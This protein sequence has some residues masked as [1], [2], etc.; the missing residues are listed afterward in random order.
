[1]GT[2]AIDP[3][4]WVMDIDP[5]FVTIKH[6][7]LR[8]LE[9]PNPKREKDI[10]LMCD[11]FLNVRVVKGRCT[12]VSHKVSMMASTAIQRQSRSMRDLA[13]ARAK[14]FAEQD[15][16]KGFTWKQ[17]HEIAASF[18]SVIEAQSHFTKKKGKVL[19]N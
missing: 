15:G 12:T 11:Y 19:L 8:I 5:H 1:V 14:R 2:V 7:G 10:R 9:V 3:K 13:T 4:S 6:I 17:V 18:E 16:F